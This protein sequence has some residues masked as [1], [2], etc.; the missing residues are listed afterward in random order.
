MDQNG[1]ERIVDVPFRPSPG[2]PPGVEVW[3]LA[4]LT[5]QAERDRVGPHR[6]LR[7]G[8]HLLIALR[9][10]S[11]CCRVDG[12]EHTVPPGAWLWVR[13]GQVLRLGHGLD[14]ATGTALLFLQGFAD[15]ATVSAAHLGPPHPEGPL[16]PDE[17]QGAAL[18]ATLR[19]L[20]DTYLHVGALP[21][22]TH[23]VLTRHL[24]AAL[25]LRLGHLHHTRPPHVGAGD[26]GTFQRF[27]RAVER[28]FAVTRRVEDYA[29]ALG[30]SVRTL[31][32]ACQAATSRT[33]KQYLDDRA[34]LEARRLL[35][36]TSLTPTEIGHRLGFTS[37]T[38]FTKFFRRCTG[39]TPAAFRVRARMGEHPAGP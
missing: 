38:V 26:S 22:D 1:H 30:Y 14:G 36:H 8:F 3:D 4:R 19:L 37:P 25:V 35:M 2:G 39:E 20:E 17:R 6:P 27:H 13:P 21:V 5:G 11:L 32:R 24:L 9:S 10:G 7:L 31:T 16:V 33:A 23:I 15:A 29:A 12:T 18:D 34:A 28:D